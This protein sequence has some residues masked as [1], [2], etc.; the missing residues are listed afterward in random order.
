MICGLF[1][2]YLFSLFV[3]LCVD[4]YTKKPLVVIEIG[5]PMDRELGSCEFPSVG[6]GNRTLVFWK[7]R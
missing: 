2:L 5:S 7:S 1:F 6:A 3:Y 4:G